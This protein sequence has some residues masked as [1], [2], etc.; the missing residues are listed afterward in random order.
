[1]PCCPDA[2]GAAGETSTILSPKVA[3]ASIVQIRLSISNAFLVKG[4]R[5]ILV[6]TGSPRD[7]DRILAALAREGVRGHELALILH[8]HGHSD[9][10]GSTRQL[11]DATS[12]P[13]AI[14]PADAAAMDDGR[15]QTTKPTCLMAKLLHWLTDDEFP[16]I[17]PDILLPDEMDLQPFGVDA[18]VVA[19]PGHTA[20]SVSVLLGNGEAVVGDMLMGGWLGGL[21]RSGRPDYPYYADD[22]AQ[23]RASVS[24]VLELGATRFYAGHGGPMDSDRVRAWLERCR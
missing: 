11:K 21:L 20:G 22:L 12:A 1:M 17:R 19:T 7:G 5:P 15:N 16:S 23:L 14:H 4:E 24:R 6:D 18:R 3:V 10:C 2:C 13:T 8:T 9:H